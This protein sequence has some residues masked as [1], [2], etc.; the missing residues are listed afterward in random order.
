MHYGQKL[1]K[2][3][4]N[5]NLINYCP[6]SE[7]V[8]EVSERANELAQRWAQVKRA[9]RSKRTSEWCERIDERVA[10]F[11][12]RLFLNHLA[13]RAVRTDISEAQMHN[14]KDNDD[15]IH[16]D[17]NNNDSDDSLSSHIEFCGTR[18]KTKGNKGQD[19]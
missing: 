10:Q 12:M 13:H 11:S 7:G 8:S 2:F 18:K 3:R 15:D 5:S 4:Q 1:K 14:M 17:S 19:L 16:N 6:T 9:V